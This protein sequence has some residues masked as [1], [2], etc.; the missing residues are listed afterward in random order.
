M[1]L[2]LLRH[3]IAEDVSPTGRDR[4][5]ALTTEGSEK[6]RQVIRVAARAGMRPGRVLTSPYKRAVQT[7]EI[8]ALVLGNNLEIS[9]SGA[10]TPNSSPEEAWTEIRDCGSDDDLLVV[11]HDPLVS[12]LLSLMLGSSRQV[13]AFRK[14]GLAKLELEHSGAYPAASLGWL[15]TPALAA[16]I[17]REQRG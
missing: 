4:D 5:R 12:A 9:Y 3:A 7:A 2:Y 6:L 14:A 11:T 1:I 8:A 10:L 15:L 16:A 17:E 13:H